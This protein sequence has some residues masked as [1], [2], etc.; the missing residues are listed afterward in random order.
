MAD[1]RTRGRI[2]DTRRPRAAPWHQGVD[3]DLVGAWQNK[4]YDL[5]DPAKVAVETGKAWR[6]AE[7]MIGV[8]RDQ[9]VRL[10]HNTNDPAAWRPVWERLG[11][12]KEAKDYDF[13]ISNTPTAIHSNPALPIPCARHSTPAA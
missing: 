10:P 1:A 3:A 12:P 8:P 2:R 7:K 11:A 4:G 6:E 5:T 9:L 13:A